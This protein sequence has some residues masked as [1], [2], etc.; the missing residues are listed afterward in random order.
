MSCPKHYTFPFWT[1]LVTLVLLVPYAGT[2]AIT[3]TEKPTLPPSANPDSPSQTH[4]PGSCFSE[5]SAS[6][7]S[8]STEITHLIPIINTLSKNSILIKSN[9]IE[10]VNA[11][12][13]DVDNL[14]S[15]IGGNS[16]ISGCDQSSHE[17]L[18]DKVKGIFSALSSI[19]EDL[20]DI[21][22]EINGEEADV[23]NIQCVLENLITENDKLGD[24]STSDSSSS[25]PIQSRNRCALDTCGKS[26][27]DNGSN[28]SALIGTKPVIV[29]NT[30]DCEPISTSTT[31]VLP[32]ASFGV[33][34]YIKVATA[35]S[36]SN[37]NHKRRVLLSS[38][39]SLAS[40]S[41][42][43]RTLPVVH[44]PYDSYVNHLSV[45]VTHDG[46]W[47]SLHQYVTGMFFYF[48]QTQR[49]AWGVKGLYGCTAVLIISQVGAYISHIFEDP[50][51][52][53][54]TFDSWTPNDWFK[55]HSFHA[56]RDGVPGAAP[57][58]AL[59]RG[60]DE[61]PGP[62]HSMFSP[63]A[64]VITPFGGDGLEF[65]PRVEWLAN[66]LAKFLR[67]P[68]FSGYTLG[69][70]R[71]SPEESERTLGYEGRAI[72]EVDP[73]EYVLV[74]P[75]GARRQMGRWRLWVEDRMVDFGDY[76]NLAGSC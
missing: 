13:D 39:E 43:E 34:E 23:D 18:S 6:A 31:S 41:L 26:C 49:T 56:L 66:R 65:T 32:S 5:V 54:E 4:S 51:F 53:W 76:P 16:V 25:S 15:D 28:E 47:I 57:S 30:D 55:S 45:E 42:F 8:I 61:Q 19:S 17:G 29:S 48:P 12:K 44:P 67:G 69:Y 36:T 40:R 9:A 11:V 74:D 60:T 14:L 2:A 1:I 70:A 24:E 72:L 59:L 68:G 71:T 63:E 75:S 3:S 33:T 62:L 7:S 20:K 73:R 21:K 35:Q 58:V 46:G 64:F 52:F 37:S 50:V 22:Y 10:K 38:N 27:S